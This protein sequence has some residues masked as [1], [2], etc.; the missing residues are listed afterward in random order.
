MS[1]TTAVHNGDLDLDRLLDA[2]QQLRYGDFSARLPEDRTGRAGMIARVFN[3]LATMPEQLSWTSSSRARPTS[4]WAIRAE[5]A[6]L[7]VVLDPPH[8]RAESD[9][10]HALQPADDEQEREVIEHD[11]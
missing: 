5:A 1:T 9:A 7:V 6:E 8:V 2:L 3:S 4:S 10:P 11:R